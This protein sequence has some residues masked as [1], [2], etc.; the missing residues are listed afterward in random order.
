M[1]LPF[2]CISQKLILSTRVILKGHFAKRYG[3]G[4]IATSVDLNDPDGKDC[5]CGKPYPSF[6]YLLDGWNDIDAHDNNC[7]KFDRH[8]P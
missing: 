8:H 2:I 1:Y 4:F 3:A 7:E 5:N 6:Y